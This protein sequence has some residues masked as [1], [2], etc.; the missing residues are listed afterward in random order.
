MCESQYILNSKGFPIRVLMDLAFRVLGIGFGISSRSTRGS[1]AEDLLFM[2]FYSGCAK[3]RPRDTPSLLPF[4][5]P[6]GKSGG[7]PAGGSVEA[8][9]GP[10]LGALLGN[11]VP[12]LWAAAL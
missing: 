5:L 11:P 3:G 10:P 1:K 7:A 8:R 12:K 6:D 4:Y 2:I 9:R